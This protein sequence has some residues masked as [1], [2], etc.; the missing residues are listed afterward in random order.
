V[1]LNHRG[2]SIRETF[3][4][5]SRASKDWSTVIEMGG[6]DG[7]ALPET[8]WSRERSWSEVGRVSRENFLEVV[9][10]L[11]QDQL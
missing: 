10:E 9:A 6:G 8:N 3:G 11:D 2:E 5:Y 1:W 7:G 4:S